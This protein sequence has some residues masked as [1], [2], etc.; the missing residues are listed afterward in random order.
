MDLYVLRHGVAEERDSIRYPDD[1]ER[2]L[3]SNGLKRLARQVKGMSTLKICPD[4]IVTSPLVRAVQTAEVVRNG[5]AEVR[6]LE[7]SDSLVPWADPQEILVE[8]R[9]TH[10]T[11]SVMVVGHEPH[12]SSLIS[13]ASSGTLNCSI[14]LKKGALCKLRIPG[15]D[16]GRCGRI[17]WSLTPKQMMRMG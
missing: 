6:Q 10:A 16:P 12:L 7:V 2:P 14:R 1:R 15:P 9:D 4:V 13:L 3:T 11:G 5:L 8:L 17:E